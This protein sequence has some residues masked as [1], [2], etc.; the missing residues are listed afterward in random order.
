MLATQGLQAI[1]LPGGIIR[2][3]SPS[4]LAALDSIEPLQ[5]RLVQVNYVTAS[6]LIGASARS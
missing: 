2:V 1:E 5:T 3:D 6:S 4:A